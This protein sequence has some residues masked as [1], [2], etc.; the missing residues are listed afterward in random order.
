M[1]SL[2]IRLFHL[3]LKSRLL[4]VKHTPLLW[5]FKDSGLNKDWTVIQLILTSASMQ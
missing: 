1:N 4:M 2:L 5:R 3:V